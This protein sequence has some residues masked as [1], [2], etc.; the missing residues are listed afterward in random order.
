VCVC[1][2]VFVCV[3]VRV[4]VRVYVCVCLCVCVCVCVCLFFCDEQANLDV[5]GK[6]LRFKGEQ[7]LCHELALRPSPPLQPSRRPD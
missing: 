3:C 4:C 1:V 2:H 5:A 7:E 6:D